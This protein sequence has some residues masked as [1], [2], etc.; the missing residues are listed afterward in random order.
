MVI[1]EINKVAQG[2]T[3]STFPQAMDSFTKNIQHQI[4]NA[5]KQLQELSSNEQ[6]TV[7][8]KM[9]KRQE[10]QKEIT[11]LNQQLRQHQIEKRQ[12]KQQKATTM[13]K[14]LGASQ[15]SR[16]SSAQKGT[17]LSSVNMQALISADIGLEQSQVQSHIKNELKGRAGI[18]RTEIKLDSRG[19]TAHKEAELAMVEEKAKKL[20]S[21]QMSM[22]SAVQSEIKKVVE[23]GEKSD[24]TQLQDKEED[25]KEE[26]LK[27][28]VDMLSEYSHVDV[29]L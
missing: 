5:Q 7:D 18:L 9:K 13:D 15:T 2:S 23:D 27:D 8:E 28:S 6:L 4:T 29:S 3:T 16:D 21:A 26:P 19:N 17:G 24:E 20:D 1:Q 14:M 11:D 10:I 12:E 22:L 25:K